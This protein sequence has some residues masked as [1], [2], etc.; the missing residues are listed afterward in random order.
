LGS[1]G[2]ARDVEAGSEMEDKEILEAIRASGIT[3][4]ELAAM[5]SKNRVLI[6]I[7]MKRAE[8]ARATTARDALILENNQLLLQAIAPYNDEFERIKGELAELEAQAAQ[9]L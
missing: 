5:L 2:S 9:T 3:K 8:L 1:A 6:T 7:E 4:E